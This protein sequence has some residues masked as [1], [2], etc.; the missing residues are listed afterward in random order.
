MLTSVS[1]SL[2]PILEVLENR[3]IENLSEEVID[4]NT[5]DKV[6]KQANTELPQLNLLEEMEVNVYP[7]PSNGPLTITV[8]N[9]EALQNY[10]N[11][12]VFSATGQLLFNE[13]VVDKKVQFNLT[14]Y[15]PCTYLI[16]I[17][18][19]QHTLTKRLIKR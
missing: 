12:I 14:D 2:A 4:H 18:N 1:Q 3:M 9:D 8:E 11:V 17:T 15:A 7:N 16:K 10:T 13:T 5:R 19:G 6:V